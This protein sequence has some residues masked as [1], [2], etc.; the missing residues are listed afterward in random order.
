MLFMCMLLSIITIVHGCGDRHAYNALLPVKLS[1]AATSF[2]STTI[3]SL[4]ISPALLNK[5]D[6]SMA[7]TGDFS[8]IWE[9]AVEKYKS[10]AEVSRLPLDALATAKSVEDILEMVGKNLKHFQDSREKG[11]K[12]R[13]VLRPIVRIV[14]SMAE[15]AGE[16][17]SL[18]RG[19][20]C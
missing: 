5:P 9:K 18:V 10:E 4:R 12:I 7:N 2:V 17:V 20:R 16:G 13:D 19:P 3:S 11:K 14:Q 15:V 6:S 1:A 8:A